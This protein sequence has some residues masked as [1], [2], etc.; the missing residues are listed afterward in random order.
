MA[1]YLVKHRDNST[2]YFLIRLAF[3]VLFPSLH[4]LLLCYIRH[5][6][7][8]CPACYYVIISFHVNAPSA[9]FPCSLY[10]ECN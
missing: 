9:S 10:V 6:C 8:L 3:S 1:W 5:Y 2:F 7:N 4:V